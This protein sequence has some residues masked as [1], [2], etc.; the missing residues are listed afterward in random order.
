MNRAVFL[1]RDGVLNPNVFNPTTE[2]WESPH[3][4]ED[5]E[6]F[7]DVLVSLRRLRLR[8]RLFL[9]SNQPS[10]SKGKTSLSN[11]KKIHEKMK[12]VLDE[13]ELGF[14]DYFYC[15]H[16]PDGIVPE[17][18]GLCDCRKPSPYFLDLAKKKFELNM[19]QS[20]MVGDRGT[21]IQCGQAGGVRTIFIH[22]RRSEFSGNIFSDFNARSLS[23]ATNIIIEHS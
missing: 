14:D 17:Y 13:N 9:V 22:G 4:P 3:C 6:L 2:K 21:D 16:H 23:E 11:I 8:Y 12:V 10:Y 19:A 1:D 15:Y 5:F 18:S 20:W 7:P